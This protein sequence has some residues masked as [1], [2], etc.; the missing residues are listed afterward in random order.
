MSWEQRQEAAR[1]HAE[2]ERL[3]ALL[4][5]SVEEL[6]HTAAAIGD[7]TRT[8][9]RM[10]GALDGDLDYAH[11]DLEVQSAEIELTAKARKDGRLMCIAA[12]LCATL[13]LLVVFGAT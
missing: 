5:G 4:G 8:Q 7:E 10:L 2:Q 1:D 9:T 3:L 11:A 12:G 6:A 13:V